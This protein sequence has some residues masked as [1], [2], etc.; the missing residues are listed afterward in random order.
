MSNKPKIAIFGGTFN[1]FHNG[2]LA[3]VKSIIE[4]KLADELWLLVTP[5]NP[6]K[7]NLSLLPNEIRFKMVTDSVADIPHVKVS[8]YEFK[9]PIPS[10]T[11]D[12]LKNIAA[13]YPLYEFVLVI[14]ADNWVDFDKWHDYKYIMDNHGI[15]VYPRA[16]C[17][18][19]DGTK[20]ITILK[21][22]LV[23]ISSTEIVR[24]IKE[25]KSIENLVPPSVVETIREK[26]LF[27]ESSD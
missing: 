16:N 4:S 27:R 9:L 2:H 23:N 20:G 18:I 8:D 7:K 14:G 19:P 15:I 12:T 3:I 21:C 13:D 22:P 17:T 26:G 5:L 11:S 10:Y 24:R 1:P 6:W 25:G